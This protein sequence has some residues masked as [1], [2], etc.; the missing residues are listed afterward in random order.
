MAKFTGTVGQ[1]IMLHCM[2]LASDLHNCPLQGFTYACMYLLMLGA[3]I[4]TVKC[5]AISLCSSAEVTAQFTLCFPPMLHCYFNI[6]FS[7]SCMAIFHWLV[8]VFGLGLGVLFEI[9]AG[10]T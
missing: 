10:S 9:G 7:H 4:S 5:L 3:L 1:G 6:T 8:L 2:C